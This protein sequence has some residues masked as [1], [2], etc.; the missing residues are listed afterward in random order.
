MPARELLGE[1]V[2][3][4]GFVALAGTVWAL[5]PPHNF[6]AVPAL[7]C[8]AVFV[9]ASSVHIDTPFGY[10]PP[11]QLAFVPLVF[12]M[13]L[14]ARPAGRGRRARHPAPARGAPTRSPRDQ[15]AP[16]R[17]ER[18]VRARSGGRVR[19]HRHTASGSRADAAHS[20]PDCPVRHRF[21]HLER[22]AR[23][24]TRRPPDCLHR[25]SLGRR[26]RRMSVGRG[27]TR[28]QAH[29][30]RP[31]GH[32]GHRATRRRRGAV[33]TGA[34]PPA[35]EPPRAEQRVSRNGARAR[36]RGRGRRWL[37]GGA[38]QER[39][40]A[41]A[42]SRRRHGPRRR[43][44]PQPRIRGA[45]ARHRQDRHSQRDHQQAR[46]ARSR[47]V[48]ADADAHDRGPEDARPRWRVHVRGGPHRALAPR[49]L[50]RRRLS[51][52]PRRRGNSARG[53]HHR[54]LRHMERH[55]DRSLLPEG[56]VTRGRDG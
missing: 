7:L 32:P 28:R 5:H 49:A 25:S 10:T 1:V 6:A 34:T 30:Q 44:A 22:A 2:V 38:L 12:A 3:G 43:A 8:L 24:R 35:P 23:N 18:L 45:P 47:R 31:R 48:G 55:A 13:P 54:L 27:A 52:R 56:A 37:H 11:T 21:R 46:Q 36:R 50:G 14:A 15:T 39:R 29:P 42:R 9:A 41:G 51:R 26:D 40:R 19:V 53:A 20:R 33:R 4:L 17:R 16:L